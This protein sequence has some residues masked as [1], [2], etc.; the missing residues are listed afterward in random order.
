MLPLP[1]REKCNTPLNLLRSATS[2]F[3]YVV[4]WDMLFENLS[5]GFVSNLSVDS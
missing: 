3:K 2:K 4:W 5:L 1:R